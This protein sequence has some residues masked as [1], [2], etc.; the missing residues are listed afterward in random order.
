VTRSIVIATCT[1][2]PELGASDR[3]L[4][5][6]LEARGHDV[7]AAPWN[8]GFA[9]FADAAAIVIRATWDYH[10]A[11]GAYLAW[12]E[13]L[14]PHR[15][16]NP[17]SLIRWN[18]EKTHV[19]D[20][21]RRGATVPR[22]LAVAADPAA[23]GNALDTL[24]L[25]HAVIKPLVGA[26]GFGVERVTRG[27]E[28]AALKRARAAKTTDRVLV[29][30]FLPAIAGGELAGVFFDGVFSHTLR[31]V[32][33]AG[34]FRINSRY[35]GRMHAADVPPDVVA[36]MERVLALVPERPLYAR[37]D[38]VVQDGR[39]V[40]MEVEV[41]EPGLGLDLAP[42]AAERFADALLARLS[43]GAR[44]SRRRAP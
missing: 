24:G 41:N 11:P 7:A 38:G 36:Q 2:W 40:V 14:D 34:E 27:D 22:T 20:L 31:R 33:A 9:P 8:A 23:I 43:S 1:A 3:R 19:L 26:S 6:A 30:E 44:P 4:A 35:G 37:V 15:T 21:A 5:G 42:G 18:L 16:F 17:P 10:E 25:S 13:R 28:A 39:F 12:L 29:Q 32:P